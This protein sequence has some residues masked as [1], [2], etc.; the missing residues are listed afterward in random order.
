[1]DRRYEKRINRYWE[2]MEAKCRDSFERLD[3][4]EWFD[5]WHTHPDW[6]GKGNARPENRQRCDELT[7]DMLMLA[8]SITAHRGNE[9]QCFA[10]VKE[11][12]MDNSVYIHS[13]NPNDSEFPFQYDGVVWG[14]SSVRLEKIVD[15]KYHEVGLFDGQDEKTLFIRKNA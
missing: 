11:D 12:T 13:E 2:K 14:Y 5:L 8:E 4:N 6:D 15:L 9:V 3:T 10:L 7:Y 1:M